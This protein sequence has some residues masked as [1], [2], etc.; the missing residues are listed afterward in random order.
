[1]L[2]PVKSTQRQVIHSASCPAFGPRNFDWNIMGEKAFR[3]V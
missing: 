2:P 1:M 3:Q